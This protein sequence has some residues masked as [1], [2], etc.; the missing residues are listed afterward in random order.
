MTAIAAG[1]PML[2][3]CG[4]DLDAHSGSG[5][6]GVP[7]K[8]CCPTSK[9]WPT[10]NCMGWEPAGAVAGPPD[11]AHAIQAAT[12]AL[13][14]AYD[15]DGYDMGGVASIALMAAWSALVGVHDHQA[16]LAR[17]EAE[18]LRWRLDQADRNTVT[19]QLRISSARA[20]IWLWIGQLEAAGAGSGQLAAD[21]RQFLAALDQP[22]TLGKTEG[23]DDEPR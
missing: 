13:G 5:I 18:D 6:A 23:A 17:A 7:C 21:M 19:A 4:H 15:W 10:G 11:L 1:P 12:K 16:H 8:M 14:M 20:N 9:G 22:A 3:K 2:C